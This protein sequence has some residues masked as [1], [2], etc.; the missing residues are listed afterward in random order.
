MSKLTT[1]RP[2]DADGSPVEQPGLELDPDGTAAALLEKSPHA[3][4]SGPGMGMWA[5]RLDDADADRP[6][7]VVWL[8]PDA[9]EL[10]P[11]THATGS[12]TFEAVS[13]TLTVVVDGEAREIAAGDSVTVEPGAEHNFRNDTDGFVAFRVE[14][15]WARTVA[16]QYTAFGKDHEGAFG[17]DGAY[18]EPGLLHGLLASEAVSEETKISA[19]PVVVQR[20]LWATIGRVGKWLGHRGV[21]QRFLA[22]EFWREHVEQPDLET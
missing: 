1:G 7:M 16:M 18:S 4:A 8:A 20:L 2:L 6:E 5:V 22:D 14:A 3:L 11:H 9:T 12:E 17:P 10:P 15:P 19:G 13:G 21:D